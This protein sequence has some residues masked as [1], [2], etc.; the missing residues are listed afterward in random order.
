[1][2]DASYPKSGG[3]R[4][5]RLPQTGSSPDSWAG[6]G[7]DLSGIGSHTNDP[8]ATWQG[9]SDPGTEV[10]PIPEDLD[11]TAFGRIEIPV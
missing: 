11:N 3:D 7:T 5:D 4:Y 6:P 2:H 10:T 9:T 8:W 1:M